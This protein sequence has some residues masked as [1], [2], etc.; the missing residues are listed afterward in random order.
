VAIRVFLLDR[1]LRKGFSLPLNNPKNLLD[2]E[3]AGFE[4]G[5]DPDSFELPKE[6][7]TGRLTGAATDLSLFWY[8]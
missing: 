5:S 8:F 4:T 7:T 1:F 6:R 3:Y 2:L